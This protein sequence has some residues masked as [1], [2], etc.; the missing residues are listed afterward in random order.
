M[1]FLERRAGSAD[2]SGQQHGA[3]RDRATAAVAALGIATSLVLLTGAGPAEAANNPYSA[4]SVCGSSYTVHVASHDLGGKA[5]LHLLYSPSS[6]Y[7]CSVTIKTTKVG[8][9]STT[10]AWLLVSGHRN[11][12][13][14]K[15]SYKY[16]AGPVKSYARHTCVAYAGGHAGVNWTSGWVGCR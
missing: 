14:D 13:Y 4:R 5:R 12:K 16:Y 7:N 15:G 9:P 10:E 2:D 1:T 6:G 3:G 8:T 11:W